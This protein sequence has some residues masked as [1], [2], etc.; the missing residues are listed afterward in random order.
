MISQDCDS[1]TPGVDPSGI[2]NINPD[3]KIPFQV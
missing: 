1:L 3:D 2:Y